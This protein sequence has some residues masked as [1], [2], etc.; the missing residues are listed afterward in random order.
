MVAISPS[1]RTHS[2]DFAYFKS[3]GTLA[4]RLLS[5]GDRVWSREN[6]EQRR[7]IL[8]IELRTLSLEAQTVEFLTGGKATGDWRSHARKRQRAAAL[9]D[10]SAVRTA[11]GM[12]E[13]SWS[14]AA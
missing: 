3:E 9:Q 6:G 13:S 1:T 2:C 8:N 5:H 14:A 4:M 11:H 12:R 10:L 7:K